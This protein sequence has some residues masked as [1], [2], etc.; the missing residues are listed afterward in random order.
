[1]SGWE[2]KELSVGRNWMPDRVGL[3]SI[4]LRKEEERLKREKRGKSL[5]LKLMRRRLISIFKNS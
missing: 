5:Y 2:N 3:G 4:S 1:M